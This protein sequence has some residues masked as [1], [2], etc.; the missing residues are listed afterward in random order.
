MMYRLLELL[1]GYCRITLR[2]SPSAIATLFLRKKVNVARM[3]SEG[4]CVSFEVLR[5]EKKRLLKLLT[6][7]P[8]EII[9]QQNKGLPALLIRYRF[10]FGLMLGAASFAAIVWAS[11]LFLWQIEIVGNESLSDR[12]ILNLLNDHGFS[13]GSYLPE[14][15][16]KELCNDCLLSDSRLSYLSINIIGTHCEVQVKE[17]KTADPLPD[18]L[19]SDITA[20]YDG[21]IWRLEVY[22]GQALVKAGETV[23]AGQVVIS[24]LFEQPD[25]TFRLE[26]AYGK[27]YAKILREFTVT[28]P[29]ETEIKVY[30]GRTIQRKSLNFFKKSIKLFKNSGI[31]MPSYD[32]IETSNSFTIGD[33]LVLPVSLRTTEYR[34]YATQTIIRG[35]D[36]VRRI[37]ETQM[38]DLLAAELAEAEVL[39]V[40]RTVSIDETGCHISCSI[41][42]IMDIAN[43]HKLVGTP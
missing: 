18:D 10:R 17:T 40:S 36:E 32:T 42:C 23:Q 6:D 19:P 43:E 29:Y 41:Y 5:Y 28:V 21:Q 20:E 25:G 7:Y 22:S 35:E 11:S 26:R 16:V 4:D 3:K 34:E 24:G 33:S 15:S 31:S 8:F 2:G 13:I 37:A 12:E 38:A 39:T 14:V 9:S 1:L 27:V 30:T